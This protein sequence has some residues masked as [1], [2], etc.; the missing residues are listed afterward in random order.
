MEG[1]EN[2]PP[3]CT[4]PPRPTSGIEDRLINL[5]DQIMFESTIGT[6]GVHIEGDAGLYTF[7]LAIIRFM[8]VKSDALGIVYFS[9]ENCL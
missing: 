6:V 5:F 3:P 9:S 4:N 8:R 1:D 2:G 7:A